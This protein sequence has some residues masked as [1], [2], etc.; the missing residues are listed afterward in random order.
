MSIINNFLTVLESRCEQIL[1]I[2]RILSLLTACYVEHCTSWELSL[3]PY[4]EESKESEHTLK[5]PLL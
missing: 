5:R 2:V 4:V 1:Y 3:F